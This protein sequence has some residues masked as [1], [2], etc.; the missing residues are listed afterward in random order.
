MGSVR[1][2]PPSVAIHISI[3]FSL[4]AVAACTLPPCGPL[5]YP[6]IRG[7][8]EAPCSCV[9]GWFVLHLCHV[10]R[11]RS[12][13]TPQKRACAGSDVADRHTL[14]SHRHID[15]R[16]S[17]MPRNVPPASGR[18]D[19]AG[20]TAATHRPSLIP[21]LLRSE[22]PR[23]LPV[24][25][26]YGQGRHGNTAMTVPVTTD[27]KNIDKRNTTERRVRVQSQRL[28][29]RGSYAA[30]TNDADE[31]KDGSSERLQNMSLGQRQRKCQRVGG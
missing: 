20:R 7:H 18:A 26:Q 30:S 14:A 12:S 29:R 24:P 13:I 23:K 3:Q 17:D 4:I 1:R 11:H 25:D 21:S 6:R 22:L 28:S 15:A 16:P 27:D 10:H 2:W 31:A 9:V 19:A 5:T 8:R